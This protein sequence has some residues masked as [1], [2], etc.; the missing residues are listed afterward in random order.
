[1]PQRTKPN[2]PIVAITAFNIGRYTTV[3]AFLEEYRRIGLDAI[4]LNGR[5]RQQVVDDLVPYVE[6]G[7]IRISSLHVFCPRPD[8]VDQEELN[9]ASPAEEA[10]RLA[11][12]CTRDTI[13]TAHQ[14]GARA[15]VV[16]PGQMPS[17]RPLSMEVYDIY[18]DEGPAGVRFLAARAELVRRRQAE[19]VPYVEAAEKSLDQLAGYIVQQGWG[20][21]LGLENNLYRQLPLL[22][23]YDAWFERF[24]G[25]PIGLW[26]DIGH[27]RCLA[28]LGLG[29]MGPL[30]ERHGH[31][32]LGLHLHDCLGVDDHLVPGTGEIDFAVLKPYLRPDVLR[33][34]EYGGRGQPLSQIVEGIRHL[35]EQGVLGE[36]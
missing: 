16:H 13:A 24:D 10:R 9:L 32:L 21:T 1:M 4:E 23:E 25:A 19:R 5:V 34:L 2:Q 6:R 31:K 28:N 11:V 12:A 36:S 33:V 22:E 26:L 29:E 35:K 20:V 27:A 17:L 15:V 7:E 8:V 14:L 18:R 30:L 3:E